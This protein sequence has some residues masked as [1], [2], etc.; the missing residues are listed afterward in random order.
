MNRPALSPLSPIVADA[1]TLPATLVALVDELWQRIAHGI[2][3]RWPPWGL[4]TL[5]TIGTAGPSARVLALRRADGAS[6]QLEFHC[7]ARSEKV[8]EIRADPRVSVVFWDPGDAIEARLSGTADVECGGDGARAAWTSV[9]PLRRAACSIDAALGHRLA[10]S[11]GF[12]ALAA[13][14]DDGTAFARFAVITIV[15]TDIDW[16]WLGPRDLRRARLRW[17]GSA[18]SGD[19]TVP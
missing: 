2:D 4:P 3:G 11:Q 19:W 12:E 8:Q 6:R 5:A 13:S 1:S 18:W 15:I 14:T 7:D 10:G 16:L 9:S 17:S